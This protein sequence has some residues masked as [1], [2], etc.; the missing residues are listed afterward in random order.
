MFCLR[1]SIEIYQ[2]LMDGDHFFM[3]NDDC[4]C[5]LLVFESTINSI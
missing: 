3:M 4:Q 2:R 1:A 5:N